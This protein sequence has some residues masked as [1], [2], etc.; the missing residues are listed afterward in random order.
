MTDGKNGT[1]HRIVIGVPFRER[2]VVSSNPN[3]YP[4]RMGEHIEQQGLRHARI[5]AKR[6]SK[7]TAEIIGRRLVEI[8][9]YS[10]SCRAGGKLTLDD[11][12]ETSEV[13]DWK[14]PD[15][16][17]ACSYAASQGWLIVHDDTLTLT[18]AGLRAV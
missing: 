4:G 6:Q 9:V 15:F 3:R 16:K 13:G 14:M 2:L 18:T 1:V 10:R 11:L 17:A 8:V 7:Q 5:G 12:V